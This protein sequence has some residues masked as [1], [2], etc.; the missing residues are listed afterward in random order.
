M[1]FCHEDYAMDPQHRPQQI[2]FDSISSVSL[3]NGVLRITLVQNAGNQQTR[4]VAQL[5]LP[6]NRLQPV[7]QGIA[8]AAN[9]LTQRLNT[10]NDDEQ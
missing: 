7:L 10:A 1:S 6:I 5:L 8:D 4:E 9:R 2:F 3:A